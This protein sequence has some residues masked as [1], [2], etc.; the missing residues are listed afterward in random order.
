MQE[1]LKRQGIAAE[2]TLQIN[3][4]YRRVRYMI[5]G[6]RPSVSI[7]IPT[8]DM[9]Q[10]LRPCLES[11]LEKTTYSPFEIIVVDNGSRDAATLN[12]LAEVS[13]DSRV[14]LLRL[15][16]EFNYSRLINLGVQ[17]SEAEFVALVN[18]DVMVINPEWLE[19]M[20]SQAMQ[21]GIGAVG[22][23]LLYPDGRIQQA[24][25]ILGAGLHGVAE[26]AHRGL[27]KGD[28]GYFGRAALAQELSAVGAAC[29]LVRRSAYLEVGGFDEENLKIAFND[30]DFCLKLLERG[31]RILYTPYAELY[32][33]EHASRGSEYTAANEQRFARE[34]EFMKKKWKE[35][36]LTD[37]NYNPNLS[38]G[39]E[40]FAPAFPPRVTKPWQP[41]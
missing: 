7:I 27:P 36:L 38:L 5:P 16:E 25:V 23:R 41:T 8:R 9:S 28:Q 35:T 4:N 3:Q 37:R 26:V 14:H 34:I 6:V 10:L 20:V 24:G 32:H 40:L 12:Y 22:P 11:I 21:P 2:V 39:R 29:M 31:A 13:R 15:D 18:N 17:N 30:I 1:H 19:E 33:H